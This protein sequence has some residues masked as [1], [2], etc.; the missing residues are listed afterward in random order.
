MTQSTQ[1][2]EYRLLLWSYEESSRSNTSKNWE[3][4]LANAPGLHII[5]TKAMLRSS[6][7]PEGYDEL[8]LALTEALHPGW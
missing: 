8:L 4:R 5:P 7:E 2:T 6:D 1:E 3:W